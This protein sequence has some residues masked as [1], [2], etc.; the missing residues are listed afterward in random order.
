MSKTRFED[1]AF[2]NL[3]WDADDAAIEIYNT[4]PSNFPFPS[5][6]KEDEAEDLKSMW[7][8]AGV[9]QRDFRR[10]AV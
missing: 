10:H 6:R 1:E 7:L 8:S 9:I 4:R 5:Q 2:E 3:L